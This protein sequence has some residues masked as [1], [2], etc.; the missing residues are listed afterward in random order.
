MHVFPLAPTCVLRCRAQV[1][2]FFEA[3]CTIVVG[4][5]GTVFGLLG[6]FLMDAALNFES[7]RLLWLRMLGMAACVALMVALQVGGQVAACPDA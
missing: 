2:A 5:S 3:P 6:M 7:I 4:A 1:S